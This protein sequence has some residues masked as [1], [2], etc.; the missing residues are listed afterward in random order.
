MVN[1]TDI[2][3]GLAQFPSPPLSPVQEDPDTLFWPVQTLCAHRH[4]D[5]QTEKEE[6][7]QLYYTITIK[8]SI[9]KLDM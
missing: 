4:C 5:A 7:I 3:E 8:R 9:K 6:A 2:S 1:G